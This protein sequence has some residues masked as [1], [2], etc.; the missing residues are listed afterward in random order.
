[1]AMSMRQA[2]PAAALVLC[3][4][5]CAVTPPA[6]TTPPPSTAV[7]SA[8]PVTTSAPP[9]TT[10]TNAPPLPTT[11]TTSTSAPPTTPTQATRR[12]DIDVTIVRATGTGGKL[13]VAAMVAGLVENGGVCTLTI[14]GDGP[15]LSAESA[16]FADAQS[17]MCD[18]LVIDAV[19]AGTWSVSVTY[20][21]D[22]HYGESP[23]T[24]TEVTE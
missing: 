4:A 1:M 5:G 6:T 16:A 22:K 18:P 11:A 24:E 7:T 9:A 15:S 14:T 20:A 12:S 17:T 19:P 21:S 13:Q 10:S 3:C 23:A 8:P 2:L